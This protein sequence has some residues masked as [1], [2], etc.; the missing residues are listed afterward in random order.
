MYMYIYIYIYI[1]IYM[2]LAYREAGRAANVPA[3]CR[4][5]HRCRHGSSKMKLMSRTTMGI[6]HRARFIIHEPMATASR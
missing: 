2:H 3:M 4:A 1:Y 6:T 5:K